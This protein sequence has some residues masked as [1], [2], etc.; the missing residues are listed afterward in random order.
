MPLA[1][2]NYGHF[3]SRKLVN[4]GDRGRNRG[5]DLL[6]YVT[7][8]RRPRVTDFREQIGIYVLFG[9]N[10][11]VVYVGQTG[12]GN[13]KLFLRL[14]DHTKD[15][16][17]D[18]WENFSWFGFGR[19]NQNGGLSTAQRP[20][21]VVQ[22]RSSAALDEIESVLLQLFEPRLNKQGSRWGN[23]QEY[24]QYVPAE[25]EASEPSIDEKLAE[26]T[27]EVSNLRQSIEGND[28]G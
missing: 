25:H 13:R 19:V 5:G 4:W 6:G 3:W 26:L 2:R 23:T 16:L 7:V 1:V 12:S 11:E 10:R 27:E 14:R 15:H 8:N 24:L 22:A 21:S 18:R 9:E 20:D 28:I 17:R